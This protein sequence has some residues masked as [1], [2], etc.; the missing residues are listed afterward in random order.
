MTLVICD[1]N[2]AAASRRQASPNSW[3]SPSPA[4][5]PALSSC[6]TDARWAPHKLS[7]DSL[8]SSYGGLTPVAVMAMP[9]PSQKLEPRRTKTLMIRHILRDKGGFKAFNIIQPTKRRRPSRSTVWS[10]CSFL[11]PESGAESEQTKMPFDANG[12]RIPLLSSR[13]DETAV[14]HQT[15]EQKCMRL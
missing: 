6:N 3:V 13:K 8:N 5:T 11:P 2:G 12:I 9:D 7:S 1:L 4:Q 14:W 15:F 10:P